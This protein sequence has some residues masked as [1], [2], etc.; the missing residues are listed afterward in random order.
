M[1]TINFGILQYKGMVYMSLITFNVPS[2]VC[3]TLR[4]LVES[5][6]RRDPSPTRRSKKK[7][8]KESCY[9]HDFVKTK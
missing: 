2:V 4:F 1:G 5:S 6:V 7:N 9:A 3:C 8:R